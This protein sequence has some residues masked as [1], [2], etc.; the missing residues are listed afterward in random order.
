MMV[1]STENVSPVLTF[2]RAIVIVASRIQHIADAHLC[3]L[4]LL[5]IYF[6]TLALSAGRWRGRDISSSRNLFVICSRRNNALRRSHAGSQEEP[7]VN[8]L[9]GSRV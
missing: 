3:S 1:V 5:I 9:L 8:L 6:H 7:I 2:P 4:L